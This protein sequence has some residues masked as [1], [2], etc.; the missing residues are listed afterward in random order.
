M[1]SRVILLLVVVLW[2]C[3]G[4]D[5]PTA[6][7]GKVYPPC[8]VAGEP[9]ASCGSELEPWPD[10]LPAALDATDRVALDDKARRIDRLFH[11]VSALTTGLNTEVT[12]SSAAGKDALTAFA[13]DDGWDFEQATGMTVEAAVDGWSK[14]AGAYAGVGVAADAYRY[15]TLRDQGGDCAEVDRARELLRAD[16]DALHLATA[17][18]G[19]PGVIARGFARRDVPGIGETVETTALFDAD[20]SPLPAEKNNGTWRED[21][22]EGGLYPSYVWEDSC[23]R[24]QYVGWVIGMAAAWE[25]IADDP[26]FAVEAKA[27]LQADA[28]AM[29]RSLMTVRDSGY[30]LE[31]WDADGRATYHGIMHENGVDR[32]YLPNPING[33]NAIMSVGIVAALGYVAEASDVFAYLE[34]QLIEARALPELARDS[35]VFLDLG[36]GSNYSSFNMAFAGGWLAHRYLCNAEARD[37]I[38]QA[39]SGSVYDNGGDRQPA[40][41]QQTLYDFVHAIA[42]GGA[43]AYQGMSADP[44]EAAVESGL[45]TLQSFPDAPYFDTEI[46]NCDDTEIAAGSC[47]AVDGSTITLLGPVGW[48]DELVAAAPV[49]MS[50]RPPSNYHWRSNPYRVNG[51]GSGDGLNPAVDFR[52]TYW[53]ARWVRR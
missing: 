16:L 28:A 32:S 45:E 53:M 36:A 18:T 46:V 4:D 29:A 7:A 9:T 11:T 17:I 10:L 35:M 25:V 43:T 8:R 13:A 12:V 3:G 14:V 22:S 51:G 26:G 48:N 40:E 5:Q 52:L 37:V 41:Q 31:I 1:S 47:E 42:V 30:D 24:D 2:G 15:G 21:N 6:P 38:A 23:S 49:P 19:T 34:E 20:G 39:I 33:F 44:D 50:I 27:T